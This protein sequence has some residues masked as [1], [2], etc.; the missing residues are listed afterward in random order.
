VFEVPGLHGCLGREYELSHTAWD[1]EC[2][3][4]AGELWG[5]AV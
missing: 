4:E 3:L 1:T 5:W 2:E